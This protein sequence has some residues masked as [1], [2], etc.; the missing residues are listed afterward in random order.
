[1]LF[2][3]QVQTISVIFTDDERCRKIVGET[4]QSSPEFGIHNSSALETPLHHSMWIDQSHHPVL[5]PEETKV[6]NGIIYVNRSLIKSEKI[7]TTT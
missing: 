5:M 2:L 7:S 3:D 1:M 6:S 4:N